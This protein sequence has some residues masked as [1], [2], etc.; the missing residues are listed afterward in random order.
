MLYVFNFSFVVFQLLEIT[1]LSKN[2][3][4]QRL[5]LFFFLVLCFSFVY[6]LFNIILASIVE[7]VAIFLLN[8]FFASK[9]VPPS[10]VFFW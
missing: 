1:K 4:F 9:I 7:I 5:F 10:T 3:H 8:L 2:S 6:K